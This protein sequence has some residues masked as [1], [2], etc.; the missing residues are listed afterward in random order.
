ML[1]RAMSG[2]DWSGPISQP[3]RNQAPAAHLQISSDGG[4]TLSGVMTGET[5]STATRV[6]S[7]SPVRFAVGQ[8]VSQWLN[9][10][11]FAALTPEWRSSKTF[12]RSTATVKVLFAAQRSKTPTHKRLITSVSLLVSPP[13]LPISP[14]TKK[15]SRYWIRESPPE[16]IVSCAAADKS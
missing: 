15:G 12:C 4:K 1:F 8:L 5:L 3:A 7:R 6:S 14:G 11:F 2:S 9:L 10:R 13:L 16:F